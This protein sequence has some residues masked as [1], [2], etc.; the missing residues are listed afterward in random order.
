LSVLKSDIVLTA[1]SGRH[2]LKHRLGLL[3]FTVKKDVLDITYHSFLEL[4]DR[5]KEVN[6]GDLVLLMKQLEEGF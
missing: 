5:I 1:R 4:A 3:G 2:A 6:D